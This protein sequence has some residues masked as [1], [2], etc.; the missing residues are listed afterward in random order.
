[1]GKERNR[2]IASDVYYIHS[3]EIGITIDVYFGFGYNTHKIMYVHI[4][5]EMM[6]NNI[7]TIKV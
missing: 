2:F 6:S 4:K 1:M 5:R 7:K 3:V